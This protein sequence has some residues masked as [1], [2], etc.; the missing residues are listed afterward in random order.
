MESLF[1]WLDEFK[2]A[3]MVR[4]AFG[5]PYEAGGR[6]IIPVARVMYGAGGGAGQGIEGKG[7]GSGLGQGG[8]AKPVAVVSVG[9]DGVQ[10]H[11]I[12]DA[13]AV[14]LTAMAVGALVLLLAYR[15]LGKWLGRQV[16]GKAERAAE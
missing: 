7:E 12:V 9:S 15:G 1:R 10:V 5:E 2:G 14:S 16:Q 8:S 3:N 13:T 6:T 4:A 11:E